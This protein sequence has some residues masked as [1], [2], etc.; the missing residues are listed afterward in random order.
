MREAIAAIIVKEIEFY[1]K[2]QRPLIRT[3][4]KREDFNY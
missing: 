3:L 4:R 1:K 2:I